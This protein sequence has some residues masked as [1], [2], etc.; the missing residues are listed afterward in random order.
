MV[1]N[2]RIITLYLGHCIKAYSGFDEDECAI[3]FILDKAW[4]H[5]SYA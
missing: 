3:A 5:L 1:S 4:Q 2:F